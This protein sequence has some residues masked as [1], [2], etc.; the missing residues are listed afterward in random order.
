MVLSVLGGGAA[1]LLVMGYIAWTGSGLG[2]LTISAPTLI[3]I[4]AIATTV[5]FASY[6]ADRP[7]DG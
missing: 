2:A 4:I 1:M 3:S 7:E 5:H 6:A